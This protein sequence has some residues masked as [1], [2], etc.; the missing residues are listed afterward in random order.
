M[1][2]L[3]PS[4]IEERAAIGPQDARE[5]ALYFVGVGQPAV[6]VLQI[7]EHQQ[8]HAAIEPMR[9]ALFGGRLR[10]A[11]FGAFE[12]LRGFDVAT[13]GVQRAAPL[14][15]TAAAHEPQ[16]QSRACTP[17]EQP[18]AHGSEN[19]E[20]PEGAPVKPWTGRTLEESVAFRHPAPME[21][22]SR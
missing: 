11:T 9:R 6:C 7:T 4:A 18:T 17:E 5:R 16:D 12:D 22:C 19:S 14:H 2:E 13:V 10:E 8:R 20:D 21:G 1:P 3:E 15:V